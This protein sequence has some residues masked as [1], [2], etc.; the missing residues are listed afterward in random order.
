MVIKVPTTVSPN[1]GNPN[2]TVV[3]IHDPRRV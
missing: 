3:G 1:T 2:I